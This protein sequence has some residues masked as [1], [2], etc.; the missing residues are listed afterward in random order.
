MDCNQVNEAGVIESYLTGKLDPA[1]QEAFEQ[2][3]FGC[4]HCFEALASC[5]ALQQELAALQQA[6]PSEPL[7]ERRPWLRGWAAGSVLAGI[8]VAVG[9]WWFQ[10]APVEP[11]RPSVATAPSPGAGPQP[12]IPLQA[13][14]P[15][16]AQ[17]AELAKFRP[18]H[19]AP[20]TL[21]GAPD[22]ATQ[23]FRDAMKLYEKRDYRGAIP[24][25]RAALEL[26]P[27]A[28]DASFYLAACQLLTGQTDSAIA[29]LKRTIALGDTPYLEDARYYL[30][31][32]Y[33]RKGNAE[34]A[35]H[36]LARVVQ[37]R[38]DRES[39]ARDLLRRLEEVKFPPS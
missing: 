31:K 39:E 9:L 3:Y 11:T 38:G 26:N 7:P 25:L 4:Q 36:E 10:S 35:Q 12:D 20:V 30:A 19:Y 18:P 28:V 8:L 27:K 34:A 23:R 33:L 21:R 17:L 2:H 22:Q 32:A 6:A 37:L 1:Q 13:P 5:R 29:T 14:A 15:A 24:G 16:T